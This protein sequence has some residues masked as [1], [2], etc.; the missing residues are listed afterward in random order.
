MTTGAQKPEGGGMS[1]L[2]ADLKRWM[3]VRAR[4]CCAGIIACRTD[5]LD[6]PRLYFTI[7]H[8]VPRQHADLDALELYITELSE[9]AA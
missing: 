5:S 2:I 7:R 8:G 1:P 9:V 3:N 4:G 6:G